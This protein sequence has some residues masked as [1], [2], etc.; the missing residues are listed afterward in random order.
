MALHAFQQHEKK[1]IH[2]RLIQDDTV[3]EHN[4]SVTTTQSLLAT[5]LAIW[6]MRSWT[7]DVPA[8][9]AAGM[10]FCQRFTQAIKPMKDLICY[11]YIPAE[12]KFT[13]A[14]GETA[15]GNWTLHLKY[16]T[17]PPASTNID[18]LEQG[19]VPILLSISQ[20]RNLYMTLSTH[21]N[22]T[23]SHARL[24]A[25]IAKQFQYPVQDMQVP[26]G[27]YSK[28]EFCIQI[29]Q[30]KKGHSNSKNPWVSEAG[31]SDTRQEEQ[32]AHPCAHHAS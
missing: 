19:A 9:W 7:T 6:P 15:K 1:A 32:A 25:W 22:V 27:D 3:S 28:S 26:S 8:P 12:T 14:N 16:H 30:D 21:L 18:I 23:R 31:P 4:L 5:K 11:Q 20:M 29:I 10:Q 2:E 24:L 13:F 17:P